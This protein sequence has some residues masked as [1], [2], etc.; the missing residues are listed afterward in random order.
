MNTQVITSQTCQILRPSLNA[1]LVE[2]AHNAGLDFK[3][4]VMRFGS[5]SI[6]MTVEFTIKK[7][8]HAKALDAKQDFTNICR[9][10]G[11]TPADWHREFSAGGRTYKIVG[12]NTRKRNGKFIEIER[13]LDERR[14][15]CNKRSTG[16]PE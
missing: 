9:A 13:V 2:V 3:I 4:G 10:Y 14:F 5:E 8:E 6:K 12:I 15:C 7:S 1:V 11:L 16:M